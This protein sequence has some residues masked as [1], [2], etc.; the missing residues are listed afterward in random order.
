MDTHTHIHAQVENHEKQR[1]IKSIVTEQVAMDYIT[2]AVGSPSVLSPI[3]PSLA[4][5]KQGP[6]SP[7]SPPRC[8]HRHT[9]DAQHKL[10]C[11]FIREHDVQELLV[12]LLNPI[13]HSVHT[14]SFV[15]D[16]VPVCM[17]VYVC[18]CVCV[19]MCVY[20]CT[21][22]CVCVCVCMCVC[23]CVC[24]YVCVCVCVC[25]WCAFKCAC[26]CKRLRESK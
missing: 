15:N 4:A 6:D 5:G 9:P 22:V 10:L 24:V 16:H 17:C 25:V 18:M 1:E 20:V 3:E 7:P 23:E 12:L 21:C 2:L 19:C 26:V 14:E 11:V 8:A 13:C